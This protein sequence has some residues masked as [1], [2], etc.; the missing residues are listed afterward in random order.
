MI[1]DTEGDEAVPRI[2]T[3]PGPRIH[4]NNFDVLRLVFAACVIVSH[5]FAVT[6]N[7]EPVIWGRTLGNVGVHGFFV[8]S[9]YL[10]AQSFLRSRTLIEYT[11]SRALRI[12]PGLAVAL[13]FA[14]AAAAIFHQYAANPVPDLIDA[15]VWT[16]TWEVV[17][18]AL[19]AV[20]G[21]IGALDSAAFPAFLAAAWVV[22]L[23][24]ISSLADFV[25]VIVPLLLMFGTGVLLATRPPRVRLGILAIAGG[26]GLLVTAYYP[27]F[28]WLLSPV[29]HVVP[30]AFG[31]VVTTEQVHRVIY[32]VSFPLVVI[33][34]GR[35]RRPGIR[36]RNDLSYGAYI[37][38]WP[39]AQVAVASAAHFGITL[40]PWS[41]LMLTV[42]GT[43]PL[44]Y[45]S[46][47]FVEHPSLRLKRWLWGRPVKAED[48]EAAPVLF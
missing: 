45:L 21:I 12:V 26:I 22:F 3:E 24:N 17:C 48:D 28:S 7:V 11:G 8:I 33:W 27:V 30:F 23:A 10:I 34:V 39:V 40:V 19:V 47:R 44:A 31:P 1:N 42:V 14:A 25:L 13:A 32:L 16:L 9:G 36:L 4:T 41:V 18:Y 38:G 6:G 5:A 46:W 29:Q 15:P 20:L 37:Y 2:R 35:L 43:V